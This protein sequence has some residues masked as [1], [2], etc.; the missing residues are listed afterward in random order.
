MDRLVNGQK[1]QLSSGEQAALE[2]SRPSA[3]EVLALQRTTMKVSR[4][5]AIIAMRRAGVLA[6][7]EAIVA[8]A[9]AQDPEVLDAWNNAIEF[10]RNS[11]LIAALNALR[12]EPM[13]AEELDTLFTTA[14]GI[15]V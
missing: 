15:G 6:E 2:A 8:A 5:Q 10:Q 1:I 9:G 7:V 12:Q 14:A 11:P 3:A 13:T 4:M